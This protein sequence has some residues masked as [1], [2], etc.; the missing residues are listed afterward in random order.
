M[1]AKG[2]SSACD[3]RPKDGPAATSCARH[4]YLIRILCAHGG[5]HKRTHPTRSSGAWDKR[6]GRAAIAQSF[7]AAGTAGPLAGL[8]GQNAEYGCTLAGRQR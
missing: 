2:V 8:T 3:K 1:L 6:T 7:H 5:P 4:T